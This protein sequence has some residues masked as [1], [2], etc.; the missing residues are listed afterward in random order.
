PLHL[1]FDTELLE[2]F[3]RDVD[4]AGAVRIGDGFGGEKGALEC[5]RRADVRL[6]RACLDRGA[7]GRL[8]EIDLAAGSDLALPCEIRER[9][10]DHDEDVGRFAALEADRYRIR[11]RPH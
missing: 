4:A 11:R 9:I 7:D 6:W 8:D 2:H 3:C 10:T 1:L 5:I